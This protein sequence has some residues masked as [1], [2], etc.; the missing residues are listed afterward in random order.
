MCECIY[1][2]FI[3]LKWIYGFNYCVFFVYCIYQIQCGP[4]GSESPT[5]LH[6]NAQPLLAAIIQG[7]RKTYIAT[8]STVTHSE[9]LFIK[10]I[11][12]H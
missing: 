2:L 5:N 10:F 12:L 4:L 8:D 11:L 7:C 1:L 6:S 9:T 3:Y